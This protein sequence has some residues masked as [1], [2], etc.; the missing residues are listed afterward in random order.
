M[1][2]SIT[3]RVVCAQSKQK[4]G[5]VSPGGDGRRKEGAYAEGEELRKGGLILRVP[6][7]YVPVFLD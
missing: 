4:P 2:T 6:G 3:Q 5:A 7:D 1:S